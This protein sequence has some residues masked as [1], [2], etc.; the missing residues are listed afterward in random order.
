MPLAVRIVLVLALVGIAVFCLFGFLT[1]LEPGD[2]ILWRIGYGVIG[3]ASLAWAARIA[4]TR[5]VQ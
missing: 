3:V 4:L 2:F 5:R 1:T